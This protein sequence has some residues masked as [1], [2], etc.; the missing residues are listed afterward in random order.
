MLAG[1][2]TVIAITPAAIN[3]RA[4]N[5]MTCSVAGNAVVM[6]DAMIGATSVRAGSGSATDLGAL[7]IRRALKLPA[8]QLIFGQ[9]LFPH[10]LRR[11]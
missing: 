6:I 10:G 8:E 4:N 9:Y 7:R 3:S 2:V 11:W 5:A 1:M